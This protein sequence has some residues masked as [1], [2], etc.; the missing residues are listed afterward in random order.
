MENDSHGVAET[1]KKRIHHGENV[2]WMKTEHTEDGH[3]AKPATL[4]TPI[5]TQ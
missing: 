3:C 1:L 4:T 2:A 5:V